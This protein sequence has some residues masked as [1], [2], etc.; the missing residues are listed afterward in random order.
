MSWNMDYETKKNRVAETILYDVCRDMYKERACE[1]ENVADNADCYHLGDIKI[2]DTNTG[3]AY[4]F[5]AKND[6]VISRTGNVFCEEYKY[7]Y[8]NP[9]ERHTGFM[10]DGEYD[11]LCIVDR[12]SAKI[13]FIDFEKLKEIYKKY[14]MVNTK[15]YDAVSY[16]Y[17]VPLREVERLG[18]LAK[19]VAYEGNGEEGYKVVA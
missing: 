19:V 16:G 10:R 17:I 6:G 15:L 13:Y 3:Y 4:Y 1:I 18:A 11:F 8:E 2:T 14:R 12:V 5:D 9:K 7:Y